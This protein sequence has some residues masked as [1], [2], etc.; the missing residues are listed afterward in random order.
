MPSSAPSIQ[1][2]FKLANKGSRSNLVAR[3]PHTV[4]SI[5]E[6]EDE[7]GFTP[8]S[9]GGTGPRPPGVTKPRSRTQSLAQFLQEA[10]PWEKDAPAGASESGATNGTM[11]VPNTAVP[12]IVTGRARSQTTGS[13]GP[14]PV[15]T[16][17]STAVGP[18]TP[19]SSATASPNVRKKTSGYLTPAANSAP[20]SSFRPVPKV[21]PVPEG[22]RRGPAKNIEDIDLDDLMGDDD[23]EVSSVNTAAA[24]STT[25]GALGGRKNSLTGGNAVSASTREMIDFLSEGP[26]PSP[27]AASP[28]APVKEVQPTKSKGS[29]R[30]GR[31]ISKLARSTSVE[32]MSADKKKAGSS[33]EDVSRQTSSSG[34]HKAP[35]TTS[36]PQW[37][38]PTPPPLPP[39]V[40]PAQ[41][42]PSPA[43]HTVVR[44][45]AGSLRKP[46][47]SFSSTTP[48]LLGT[49]PEVPEPAASAASVNTNTPP[50]SRL[51]SMRSRPGTAP[52]SV[53]VPETPVKAPE[54]G[55]EDTPTQDE[56]PVAAAEESAP[57]LAESSS[58]P[59]TASSGSDEATRSQSDKSIGTDEIEAEAT[60]PAPPSAPAVPEGSVLVA[61]EK[62]QLMRRMIAQATSVEECQILVEMFLAQWGVPRT[63]EEND[64][65]EPNKELKAEEEAHEP[66]LVETL[67]GDTSVGETADDNQTD[68]AHD[69]PRTPK[70]PTDMHL[71]SEEPS[72]TST[73]AE[74]Y[75]PELYQK[76]LDSNM[77]SSV[78]HPII[79]A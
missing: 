76:N 47:P 14:S 72:T 38:R 57:T 17:P 16:A 54:E 4:E 33:V 63:A 64:E 6:D 59:S 24:S 58:T 26:P 39:V 36:L 65:P 37:T 77:L 5:E 2:A 3:P 18:A 13:G 62:A 34:S 10:P 70:T 50:R 46:A 73:A 8:G 66:P 75:T 79:A 19:G 44:S 56:A 31:M 51:S 42:T 30:F 69:V 43:Q 23:D 53:A 48:S 15:S 9:S 67:L 60:T 68:D 11:S 40:Q 27:L 20:P 22:S 21:G 52:S 35:S 12:K 71:H 78:S 29:G 49:N 1:P 61:A 45:R 7:E 25:G 32:A 55:E 74:P 41:V 28:K